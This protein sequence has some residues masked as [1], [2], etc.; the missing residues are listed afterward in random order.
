MS[1]KKKS[2]DRYREILNNRAR[3]DYH[4]EETL[5]VGI[6]LKG[7]EVKAIREGLAQIHEAFVRIDQNKPILYHAHIAEYRF[8]TDTNHKPYRPRPL[9][10]HKKEMQKWAQTIQSGGRT[11]VPI[12]MYFTKGLVK[13]QIALARGKKLH[14][15]REDLRKK[16]D[17]RNVQRAIKKYS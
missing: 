8:G 12:K 17:L 6:I 1:A 13:V 7:T 16:D 5:E 9:L 15:K 10:M 3:R 4:I 11:I 2:K 14:D